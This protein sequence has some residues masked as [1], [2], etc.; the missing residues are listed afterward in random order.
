MVGAFGL[1]GSG[2]AGEDP[3]QR[4]PASTAT[5]AA[6]ITRGGRTDVPIVSELCMAR[7]LLPGW[8]TKDSS[9]VESGSLHDPV[10]RRH[11]SISTPVRST[12]VYRAPSARGFRDSQRLG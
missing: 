9:A 5:M 1:A 4:H 8:S 3:V 10:A 2:A 12:C 6:A 7:S 11:A